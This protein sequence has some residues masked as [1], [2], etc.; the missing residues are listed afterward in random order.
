MR[1]NNINMN[2]L[3]PPP[4]PPYPPPSS[5][6]YLAHHNQTD[7]PQKLKPRK[8]QLPWQK[9]P[10]Q[11]P[12]TTGK[13]EVEG[14]DEDKDNFA[15][16]SRDSSSAVTYE[17]QYTASEKGST[18]ESLRG[19][20]VFISSDSVST[21]SSIDNQSNVDHASR[22]KNET[23][24]QGDNAKEEDI[25]G[26]Q[27]KENN[28]PKKSEK[29]NC[30]HKSEYCITVKKVKPEPAAAI[31][32]ITSSVSTWT[33]KKKQ[34][35]HRKRKPPTGPKSKASNVDTDKT[36]IA[37]K[38]NRKSPTSNFFMQ[39][40]DDEVGNHNT[41]DVHTQVTEQTAS[42]SSSSKS[43][44]FGKGD[45][46]LRFQPH[47]PAGDYLTPIRGTMGKT[48]TGLTIDKSPQSVMEG[49]GSSISSKNVTLTSFPRYARESGKLG[50]KSSQQYHSGRVNRH[51]SSIDDSDTVADEGD[52]DDIDDA[53]VGTSIVRTISD[54]LPPVLNKFHD[55][56]IGAPCWSHNVNESDLIGGFS[57]RWV[58]GARDHAVQDD[59][60]DEERS[61]G[62]LE[63]SYASNDDE[64]ASFYSSE[65]SS[66]NSSNRGGR[67]KK[68]IA[69]K[70]YKK[71]T[72][73]KKK[74]AGGDPKREQRTSRK[75]LSPR[76]GRSPTIKEGY[77]SD[78]ESLR[79]R[80]RGSRASRRSRGSLS[81]SADS[82][83]G[84]A[85]EVPQSRSR[86]IGV[87]V[88]SPY[89]MDTL[90]MDPPEQTVEKRDGG[91]G[92]SFGVV[93]GGGGVTSLSSS[94]NAVLN[95]TRYENDPS[96]VVRHASGSIVDANRISNGSAVDA[97]GSCIYSSDGVVCA[98]SIVAA[99]NVLSYDQ[100]MWLSMTQEKPSLTGQADT[101]DER[102][103]ESSV[104]TTIE[105]YFKV[106]ADK[107]CCA[108][109]IDYE[110][111]L[112]H[113]SVLRSFSVSENSHCGHPA[114][115][116]R[117]AHI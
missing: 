12:S 17:S 104:P 112:H 3:P 58:M 37:S 81:L 93:V 69:A 75:S 105:G 72:L 5:V 91:R 27:E 33:M 11:P 42:N 96:G 79:S 68:T 71:A 4:P 9:E 89:R 22:T 114:H 102:N 90:V 78:G 2:S 92:A 19:C 84:S 21:F 31:R 115:T 63:H 48:K 56:I 38:N 39:M 99:E 66:R 59:D 24:C 100:A 117:P 26:T 43:T 111:A 6:A 97:S 18:A 53:S 94:V 40:G 28:S 113:V 101:K 67:N 32:G 74:K 51:D 82:S 83:T 60:E 77:N 49:V 20:K 41:S 10:E 73:Q 14:Q 108:M 57:S 85:T 30:V 8:L 45:E 29:V 55:F 15:G 95:G 44:T 7:Y 110:G 109:L 1:P 52:D 64:D 86:D 50:G 87:S 13:R 76:R 106:S 35:S 36:P 34:H 103:S 70:K 46:G 65:N 54:S 25:N 16:R 116:K 98:S 23:I 62:S 61:S 107:F 88:S 47:C 80:S